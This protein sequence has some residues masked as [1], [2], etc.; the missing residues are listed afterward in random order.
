MRIAKIVSSLVW[1]S[2]VGL[3]PQLVAQ[4]GLVHNSHNQVSFT[5]I[6]LGSVVPNIAAGTMTIDAASARATTGGVFTSTQGNVPSV[7]TFVFNMQGQNFTNPAF[8]GVAGRWFAD[9]WMYFGNANVTTVWAVARDPGYA[10]GVVAT[11][12]NYTANITLNRVGG[13]ATMVYALGPIL[14]YYAAWRFDGPTPSNVNPGISP[15]FNLI[16]TLNVGANQLAGDYTATFTVPY[17]DDQG[18]K[19][20][21]NITVNARVLQPLVVAI[22]QPLEFGSMVLTAA[23]ATT[24]QVSNAGVRTLGGGLT[25]IALP[26]PAQAQLTVTGGLNLNTFLTLPASTTVTNGTQ[27]LTVNTFVSDW[28]GLTKNLGATGTSPLNIGATLQIPVGFNALV[29]FD[30][31]YAG[32]FNVTVAYN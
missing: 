10:G 15:P 7:G 20:S 5:N 27:T 21:S 26:A 14:P 30:G 32:T 3:A 4:T 23:P 2:T 12:V 25:A 22:V 8:P 16:G 1:V 9:Y 13:G 17:N 28:V 18:A 29:G 31:T 11:P 24:V 6:Q 19:T